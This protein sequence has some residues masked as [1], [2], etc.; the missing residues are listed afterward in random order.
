VLCVVE[1]KV[2]DHVPAAS[3]QLYSTSTFMNRLY[4]Q[5]DVLSRELGRQKIDN[6]IRA[7]KTRRNTLAPISRLP[8]EL[9]SRIFITIAYSHFDSSNGT[10]LS[11]IYAVTAVCGHWRAI[12]LE[13]PGLWCFI[14]FMYPIWT[15]EM[16][17][18]SKMAP[19]V[20]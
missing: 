11:W 3:T 15:E 12:A 16:L 18:R 19:L 10:D 7:L 4:S 9:L 17:K 2:Q 13:C 20:I 8:T 5:M 6:E 1:E 14:G